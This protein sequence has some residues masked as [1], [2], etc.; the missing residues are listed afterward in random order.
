MF[1]QE[2]YVSLLREWLDVTILTHTGLFMRGI[3]PNLIVRSTVLRHYYKFQ[4]E[5]RVANKL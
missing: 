4:I 5:K 3:M 1:K 2:L